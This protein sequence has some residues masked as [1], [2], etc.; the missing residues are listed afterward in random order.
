MSETVKPKLFFDEANHIYSDEYGNKI[1]SVSQILK[2]VGISSGGDYMSHHMEKAINIGNAVHEALET[3]NVLGL[4]PAKASIKGYF[5]AYLR[6][7]EEYKVKPLKNELR[8]V[9]VD[10][11][12]KYAG[13]CDLIAE[14]NGKKCIVDYKTGKNLYKKYGYQLAAYRKL[15]GEELPIYILYL[16]PNGEYVFIEAQFLIPNCIEL[17]DDVLVA[18]SKQ[19]KFVANHEVDDNK[20]SID[21]YECKVEIERLNKKMK[22]IENKITKT[23]RHNTGEGLAFKYKYRQ[24]DI[25]EE[26]DTHKFLEK[27]TD[28]ESYSLE[29]IIDALVDCYKTQV[30]S[31]PEHIFTLKKGK[32]NE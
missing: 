3:Y 13:T 25:K 5:T 9:S 24:P 32:K 22:K 21:W 26:F 27:F 1:P 23:M 14:V 12:V 2:E 8:M 10:S 18:Y 4:P 30:K 19:E 31:K 17:W 15:Y 16:K 20:D 29:N 7:E 11:E 6:W 28:E